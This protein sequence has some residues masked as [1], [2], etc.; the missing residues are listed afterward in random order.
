MKGSRTTL[1]LLALSPD[2][3]ASN[4]SASPAAS[5]CSLRFHSSLP[6]PSSLAPVVPPAEG[7]YKDRRVWIAGIKA[8]AD[9]ARRVR[10]RDVESAATLR[11]RPGPSIIDTAGP[12]LRFRHR[13]NNACGRSCSCANAATRTP[14]RYPLSQ[15]SC[16]MRSLRKPSSAHAAAGKHPERRT[17]ERRCGPI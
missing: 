7:R 10:A 3:I 17:S 5:Q 16:D 2:S 1:T 11:R 14:R 15:Q 13:N 6:A 9:L 8:V 12:G 4:P